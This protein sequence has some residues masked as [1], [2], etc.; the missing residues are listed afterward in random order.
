MSLFKVFIKAFDLTTER[1]KVL[2]IGAQYLTSYFRQVLKYANETLNH[3]LFDDAG[4]IYQSNIAYNDLSGAEHV[5]LHLR[6]KSYSRSNLGGSNKLGDAAGVTVFLGKKFVFSEVI[7][8]FVE[9]AGSTNREKG[10][11]LANFGF[12]E[13]VHNK[14]FSAYS[15]VNE[16]D[17]FVHANGGGGVLQSRLLPQSAGGMT[18]NPKNIQT[19]AAVYALPVKQYR[20]LLH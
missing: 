19:M 2:E 8:S 10:L 5:L 7:W 12:H 15:N 3:K 1:R 11:A 6:E 14:T 18:A 20:E 13:L 9:E 4:C 17:S 16:N